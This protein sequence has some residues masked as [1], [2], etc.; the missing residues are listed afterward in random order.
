MTLRKLAG[1]T[2]IIAGI[3]WC[4]PVYAEIPTMTVS[5]IQP[6]MTGIG[7]T[8]ISGTEIQEFN[9]E[10][11]DVFATMGYDHGPLILIRVSGSVIDASGG[12]AGGYS[13]SPVYINGRLIGAISWG[14]YFTDGTVTGVTP[15][16]EMLKVFTYGDQEE[17]RIAS[18]PSCLENPITIGDRVYDSVLL[19]DNRIQASQMATS[20]DSSTLI[21]TPCQTP[22]VVSG[23]SNE[24]F[25]KLREYAE[26]RLPYF[27]LVQGPGGG[28]GDGV[29][30]LL[31]PT[32]LE[33]G[34]SVGA[35]LATGDIDLTA[36]GTLTW[37]NDDGQFLAFGH[38]FLADGD[39][40]MPFVT[41]RVVYTM[42]ALDR[43]YKLGEPIDIVGTVNQDRM[44]AIGGQLREIPEMVHFNL[45]VIDRDTDHTSRYDFSV[46]NKEQWLPYFGWLV[47]IEG[48]G[49]ATDRVGTGTCKVSFT[50]RGEGLS[51]P[52]E[53]EN[54]LYASY[55]VASESLMEFTEVLNMLTSSNV[56]REVKITNV[57][58]TVEVTSERQTLD[59]VRARYL[60]APNM[61]P[62]AVGYRGPED[63][64]MDMMGNYSCMP[65][66]NAPEQETENYEAEEPLQDIPIDETMML[67][68]EMSLMEACPVTPTTTLVGY[69]SGDTVRLQ[70]TLRP[71]REDTIEETVELKLPDDLEPGQTM[72][73][74]M[75]GSSSYYYYGGYMDPSMMGMG[76]GMSYYY[77]GTTEGPQTL[78]EVIDQFE[79][80]DTYNTIVVRLIPVASYCADPYYYLQ[81]NYKAP[82]EIKSTYTVD[83]VVFG[84]F[85]LPIEILADETEVASE[86]MA[87]PTEEIV[88]DDSTIY[89]EPVEDE[90]GSRNP[91]RN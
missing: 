61:G 45:E 7:R 4:M 8:V 79:S 21:M 15:I 34:A 47:P 70:I 33:P 31:G 67:E 29:P 90:S 14:P 81:D 87:E 41:T 13:G 89:E 3:L 56:Y 48:L 40:N 22:L 59:I 17:E 11:I 49:F 86:E 26:E 85:T 39:T 2:A 27:Q 72:I 82:G 9:V 1:I 50:V 84:Y 77:P 16:D 53:R 55:D 54:L 74:I 46:V 38:P 44:T 5:E 30:I 18:Q 62:G 35:Q 12:V 91:H 24:G 63:A 28:G 23:F 80:R 58:I 64:G 73:E 20:Y 66:E 32:T 42:P 68:A 78:D 88:Y 69:H 25:E 83:D 57:D 37:I 43:S 65:I 19:A 71:F 75:G 36:V 52:I 60:D 10:V 76:M 51:E 6:G